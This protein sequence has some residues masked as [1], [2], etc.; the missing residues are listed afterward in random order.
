MNTANEHLR[1]AKDF[2]YESAFV[3]SF[4]DGKRLNWERP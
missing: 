1:Q 3:V 2:G 4:Q